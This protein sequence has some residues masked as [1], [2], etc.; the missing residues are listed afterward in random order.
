MWSFLLR[1]DS[2]VTKVV[3]GKEVLAVDIVSGLE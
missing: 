2:D 1:E 3:L